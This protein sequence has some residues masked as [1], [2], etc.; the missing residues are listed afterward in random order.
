MNLSII[1]WDA[2]RVVGGY[3][4]LYYFGGKH[5]IPVVLSAVVG[6]LASSVSDEY[7]GHFAR[8]AAHLIW[9][10]ALILTSCGLANQREDDI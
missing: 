10:L 4:V 5:T 1:G 3:A 9:R 2:V 6:L 7:I 8:F